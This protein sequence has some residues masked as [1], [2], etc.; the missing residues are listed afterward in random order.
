VDH[1]SEH[2]TK[3]TFGQDQELRSGFDKAMMELEAGSSDAAHVLTKTGD[4]PSSF[5]LVVIG[6]E[7]SEEAHGLF[8]KMMDRWD[9]KAQRAL[10]R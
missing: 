8:A 5:V 4:D 9:R 3:I 2:T 1:S 7:A 10:H 6:K